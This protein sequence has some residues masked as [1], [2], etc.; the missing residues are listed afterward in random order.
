MNICRH[1][2]RGKRLYLRTIGG[3]ASNKPAR[4]R[5]LRMEIPFGWR[6]DEVVRNLLAIQH[7]FMH[8]QTAR[9]V[10][11]GAPPS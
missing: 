11:Q 5:T 9:S 10:D 3:I 4:Q 6:D 7:Y 1:C 2:T 8:Q